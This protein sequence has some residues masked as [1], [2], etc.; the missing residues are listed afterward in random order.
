MIGCEIATCSN[1]YGEYNTYLYRY[2]IDNIIIIV[3]IQLSRNF[4]AYILWTSLNLFL[5]DFS[6][7][8]V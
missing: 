8:M 5:K 6:S 2:N 4:T 1:T 3:T 7:C